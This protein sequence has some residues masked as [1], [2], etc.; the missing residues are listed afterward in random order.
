[1]KRGLI[2][3]HVKTRTGVAVPNQYRKTVQQQRMF[4]MYLGNTQEDILNS[5]FCWIMLT[6][7]ANEPSAIPETS[8]RWTD[9]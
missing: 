2:V 3:L 8:E 9:G 6:I 5:Y 7:S 4:F 1:M